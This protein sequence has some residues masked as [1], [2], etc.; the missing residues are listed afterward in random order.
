M[1]NSSVVKL[2][3]FIGELC[4]TA[5][6]AVLLMYVKDIKKS[7]DKQ[8]CKYDCL[9]KRVDEVKSELDVLRGEHNTRKRCK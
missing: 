4:I 2:G 9:D 6:G 5:L 8:W 1:E 7:I 3:F